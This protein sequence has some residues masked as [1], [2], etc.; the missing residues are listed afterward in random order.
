MDWKTILASVTV[1]VD[2]HGPLG[3]NGR[4]SED[5][6]NR[7]FVLPEVLGGEM[8]QGTS[9]AHPGVYM[10]YQRIRRDGLTKGNRAT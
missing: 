2:E 8:P 4:L 5:S 6:D 3:L 1:S 9:A 7:P 10:V